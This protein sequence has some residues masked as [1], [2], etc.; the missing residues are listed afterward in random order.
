MRWMMLGISVLLLS[1]GHSFA[2]PPATQQRDASAIAT[3]QR[4][5][6]ALA[7]GGAGAINAAPIT[8][9][10]IAGSITPIAG[11]GYPAGTFTWTFEVTSSG[12]QFRNELQTNGTTRVF[13]SGH[14]SPANGSNGK[15]KHTFSHM[16]LAETPSAVPMVVL[17]S[18]VVNPKYTI[19]QAPPLQIGAIAARHVHISDDRDQVTQAVTPQEW[20]FDPTSGLP[21]RVEYRI[22]DLLDPLSSIKGARDFANYRQLGGFLVPTQTTSS[23]DG[24]PVCVTTISSVILNVPVNESEF[25]LNAEGN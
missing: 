3:L 7:G 11:S 9:V 21:L 14:G 23:V 12:Y 20:Y 13:V 22:P 10:Q 25:D 16:A 15:V 6:L 1:A 8:S 17:I 18:V 19:T 4:S 5:I 2:L 24:E